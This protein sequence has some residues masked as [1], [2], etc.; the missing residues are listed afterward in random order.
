MKVL[1]VTLSNPWC[2]K[3]IGMN[4][5]F[6]YSG[7]ESLIA[8]DINDSLKY[9]VE[10]GFINFH[11][12][13]DF[14]PIVLVQAKYSVFSYQKTAFENVNELCLLLAHYRSRGEYIFC[15]KKNDILLEDFEKYMKENIDIRHY[16]GFGYLFNFFFD[17]ILFSNST[18]IFSGEDVIDFQYNAYGVTGGIDSLFEIQSLVMEYPDIPEVK[19]GFSYQTSTEFFDV[20]KDGNLEWIG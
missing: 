6:V 3:N 13:F 19:L 5:G 1:G 4:E 8:D 17:E 7:I 16:S 11:E 10:D 14:K 20:I 9:F 2:L 18:R 15:I 12:S